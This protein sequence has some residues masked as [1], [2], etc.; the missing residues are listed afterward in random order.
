MPT[1]W[2]LAN[3][4]HDRYQRL[5]YTSELL[6]KAQCLARYPSLQP[7]YVRGWASIFRRR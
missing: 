5:D 4:L 7:D 3:E 1:E 2:T 6:T